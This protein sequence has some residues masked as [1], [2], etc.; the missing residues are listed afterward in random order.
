MNNTNISINFV[1]N[2]AD[3]QLKA[4]LKHRKYNLSLETFYNAVNQ[5][6][7]DGCSC[8]KKEN[9]VIYAVVPVGLPIKPTVL[10]LCDE[11][12]QALPIELTVINLDSNGCPPTL[13]SR[14]IESK[15]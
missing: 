2:F 1:G 9:V 5:S 13:I 3:G 10:S 7:T 12:I 15:V 4:A 11:C 6:T 8:C 14:Q